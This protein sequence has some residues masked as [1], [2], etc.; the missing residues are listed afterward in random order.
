MAMILQIMTNMEVIRRC[1]LTQE[2]YASVKTFLLI[3]EAEL[4]L[5]RC[6]E[7]IL[8]QITKQETNLSPTM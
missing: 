2:V 4:E 3:R 5:R 8:Q 6:A 7:S 1:G